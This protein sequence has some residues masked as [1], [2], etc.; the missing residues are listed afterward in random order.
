MNMA[1]NIY[2][3]GYTNVQKSVTVGTSSTQLMPEKTTNERVVWV[4][5]N[6]STLNQIITLGINSEAVA[7][8]GIVLQ[9]GASW[10]E[11]MDSRFQPVNDQVTAISSAASG[12][13]AV[14][15]RSRSI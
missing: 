10:V 3:G 15:E 12:T 8:R 2:V 1:Q 14:Y 7:N 4:V 13:V 6:T 9:P 5:V 11:S